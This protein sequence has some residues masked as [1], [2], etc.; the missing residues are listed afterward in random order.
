MANTPTNL[1]ELQIDRTTAVNK[2][3]DEDDMVSDS[4]TGL[5]T[6]QS[7]KAYVDK[8]LHTAGD[9]TE[10]STTNTSPTNKLSSNFTPTKTGNYLLE[11]YLE[12][13]VSEKNKG[14]AAR[15]TFNDD[16]AGVGSDVEQGKH[17]HDFAIIT[18]SYANGGWVGFSGF[19]TVA[20]TASQQ[21][22]TKVD[23]WMLDDKTAYIRRV[24]IRIKE[25]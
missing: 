24:R 4:A 15:I 13:A 23:W 11:W 5:A 2:I 3:L 10:S 19:S 16:S 9:E 22:T 25:I 17:I 21:T 20:L 8:E 18:A 14:A 1:K 7:I 12:V 6:Q